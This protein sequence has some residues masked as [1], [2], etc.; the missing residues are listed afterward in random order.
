MEKP[1]PHC[2]LPLSKRPTSVCGLFEIGVHLGPNGNAEGG[3]PRRTG[4]HF[5]RAKPRDRYHY[6]RFTRRSPQRGGGQHHAVLVARTGARPRPIRPCFRR[7]ERLKAVTGPDSS[8]QGD[9][10]P[11]MGGHFSAA[12]FRVADKP[13]P[14]HNPRVQSQLALRLLAEASGVKRVGLAPVNPENS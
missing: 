14:S 9:F 6:E 2:S 7:P 3:P 10:A 12:K 1:V 5:Q 11:A 13:R 8:L 4:D